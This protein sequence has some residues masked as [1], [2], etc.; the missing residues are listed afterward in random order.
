MLEVSH[1]NKPTNADK[2]MP[3]EVLGVT[4]VKIANGGTCLLHNGYKYVKNRCA[5]ETTY[6]ICS[7]YKSYKCKARL[8]QRNWDENIH[9]SGSTH[10]HPASTVAAT[11]NSVSSNVTYVDE[12]MLQ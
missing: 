3:M 11:K 6:W 12:I 1:L 7:Q 5:S 4:H 8:S 2:F 9:I 10:T